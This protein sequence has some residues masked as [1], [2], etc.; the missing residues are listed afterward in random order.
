M[1]R[2]TLLI[3]ATGLI[4]CTSC[5]K[6]TEKAYGD[7]SYPAPKNV[8]INADGIADFE[9]SFTQIATSDV[10]VSAASVSLEILGLGSNNVLNDT[11][12]QTTLFLTAGDSIKSIPADT[13]RVW[14]N[15]SYGIVSKIWN[16]S[17]W[18]SF[19]AVNATHNSPYYFGF[20][21]LTEIESFIGWAEITIDQTSGETTIK[22]YN[23]SDGSFIV[24]AQ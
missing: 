13:N 5:K 9:F 8:D 20:K 24:T 19:W 16:G 10:P 4:I 7:I 21:I 22:A 3:V 2:Y 14:T 6:R 1:K 18:S 12:R 23:E 11:T 15:F 17:E